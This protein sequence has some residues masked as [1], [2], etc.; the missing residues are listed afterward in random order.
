MTETAN[1]E[2]VKTCFNNSWRIYQEIIRF[3]YMEHQEIYSEL[4][5]YLTNNYPHPFSLLELGCGDA[6]YSAK[7]LTQTAISSYIGVDLSETGLNLAKQNLNGLNCSVELK[8]VEMWEFL[9]G[10][11][12]SFD[13]ILISFALHH[14]SSSQKQALL[15]KCYHYLNP[16]GALLLIDVFCQEHEP[17]SEYLRRYCDYVESQWQKIERRDRD[18]VIEHMTS[19]DFPE[20]VATLRTWAETMGFNRV[21]LIYN[22]TFEVHNAIAFC[23]PNNG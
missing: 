20:S 2:L 9:E 7:T 16:G 10:C 14:L 23:K 19:S 8:Q 3:N 1:L 6:F 5:K 22:G 11:S 18:V 13:L 12:L 21:E 15:N 4:E 17:R